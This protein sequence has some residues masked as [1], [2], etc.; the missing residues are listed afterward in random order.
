M[1]SLVLHGATGSRPVV[2]RGARPTGYVWM[3]FSD[4]DG[5]GSDLFDLDHARS[6]G[7]HSRQCGSGDAP[8]RA[9]RKSGHMLYA[10]AGLS[11][12]NLDRSGT[13]R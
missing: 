6:S 13:R 10:R 3:I 12:S 9:V 11:G 2:S 4:A 1:P 7:L 8:A 5:S